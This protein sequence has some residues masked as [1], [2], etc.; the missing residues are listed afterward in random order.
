MESLT[1]MDLVAL[2]GYAAELES[3]RSRVNKQCSDLEKGIGL[4][5]GCMLDASSQRALQRGRMVA[6]EIKECLRPTELV[7]EKIYDL[8]CRT[9][10]SCDPEY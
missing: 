2:K 9:E 10:S 5:S 8:I 1:E 6:S 7:L 4:C 3:F